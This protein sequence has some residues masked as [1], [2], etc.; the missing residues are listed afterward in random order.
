MNNRLLLISLILAVS[1]M[2]QAQ[3]T[4]ILEGNIRDS[5][6]DP[7]DLA[8]V[9][10]QGTQEGTVTGADGSFRLEVPVGRS[11]TVFISCMG[12][13]SKQ[14]AVRLS[15]GEIRQQNIVLLRDVRSIREVSVTA[16]QERGSTFQRIDVEE[17]NYMPSTTGKV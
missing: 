1:A 5:I 7:V 16:R 6:G 15:A 13:R 12:Y 3:D 8:T 2:V 9:G 10:L 14:F 11:Y 17:L 4:G